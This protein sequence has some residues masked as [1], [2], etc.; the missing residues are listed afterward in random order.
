M[1]GINLA[2]TSEEK[3]LGVLIDDKLVFDKHITGIVNKANRTLGMI[4]RGFACL[5]KEIFMNLY[6]VMVRPLLEYCV[7][8]WSPYRQDLINLIEGVQMRATRMVPA[9]KNKTYEERLDA[10]GLTTLIERR[11]RGDMIQTYKMLTKKE[12]TDP[13]KFF[14]MAR[15]RG[16]PSLFH[17]FKIFKKRANR[18]QRRNS[19]SIRVANPWNRLKRKE[20]QALKTSGFKSNLDKN[21]I[22]RRRARRERDGRLYIH[23]YHQTV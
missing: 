2:V 21:E 18:K 1:G 23:L 20:V 8:V 7:Q 19:F 9:L 12:D 15:E 10:L 16:D 14:Q 5:D 13:T 17:G 11:Y 3:D 6:P 4:R 22:D